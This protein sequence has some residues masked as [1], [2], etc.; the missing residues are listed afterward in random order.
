MTLSKVKFVIFQLPFQGDP[1]S[2]EKSTTDSYSQKQLENRNT[3]N[4][5]QY[6]KEAIEEEIINEQVTQL[7]SQLREI[8]TLFSREQRRVSE[9]EEQ[10]STMVQQNQSLEKQLVHIHLK[11]E[12]VKSMHEELTTLEEVR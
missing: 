10:L 4:A 1:N 8:R 2:N 5:K 6:E 9:L 11:D 3:I 12:E 7:L